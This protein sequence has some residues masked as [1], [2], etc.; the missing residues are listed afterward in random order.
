MRVANAALVLPPHKLPPEL[1]AGIAPEIT[2]CAFDEGKMATTSA[3]L[4]LTMRF[5]GNSVPVSGV[6]LVGAL[7]VYRK[8]GFL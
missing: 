8:K 1:A 3:D 2:L 6:T 7:P 5:S 4:P